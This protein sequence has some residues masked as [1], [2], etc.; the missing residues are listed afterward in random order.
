MM[1]LD[2]GGLSKVGHGNTVEASRFPKRYKTLNLES[3]GSKR[4]NANATRA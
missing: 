3:G 1:A 4:R 2:D